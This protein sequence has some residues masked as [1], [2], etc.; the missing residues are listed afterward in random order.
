MTHNGISHLQ[1]LLR[2]VEV[3]VRV[4]GGRPITLSEDPLD[5]SQALHAT[6]GTVRI[7]GQEDFLSHGSYS[8][9]L[10]HVSTFTRTQTVRAMAQTVSSRPDNSKDLVQS[11]A[12]AVL[13]QKEWYCD[14]FFYKS[15]CF[16]LSVK[17]HQGSTFIHSSPPVY[18]L[19]T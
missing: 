10:R 7:V 2:T 5:I 1:T 12:S 19:S 15:F 13:R 17:C 8:V 11:L 6:K 16:A 9:L 18:N 4:S 14:R 3:P